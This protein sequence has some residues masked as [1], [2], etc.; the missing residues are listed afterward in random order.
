MIEFPLLGIWS[1]FHRKL[2]VSYYTQSRT[3]SKESSETEHSIHGAEAS[4]K[5]KARPVAC[6]IS[7]LTHIAWVN[8]TT[9]VTRGGQVCSDRPRPPTVS[10][11]SQRSAE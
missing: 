7:Q 1:K 3:C 8:V 2:I 6:A 4:W 10:A 5:L 9:D 11:I